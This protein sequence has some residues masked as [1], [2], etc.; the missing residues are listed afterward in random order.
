M[1]GIT[2]ADPYRW[3]EDQDSAETRAW[4]KNE[5]AYTHALLDGRA[6]RDKLEARFGQLRKVNAV[7]LPIERSGRYVYRKRLADQD[8]YVIYKREGANGQEEVLIDPNPMSPDHSTNVEFMDLSR[9]G[10][11]LAYQL[12]QGGKDETEI[13]TFDIDR[14]QNL[15]DTLPLGLYF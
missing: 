9:D 4:N 2:I 10:K 1:H 12:R 5:N 6:G 3:L 7:Q 13:H 14:H 15:A 8:Q 11:V